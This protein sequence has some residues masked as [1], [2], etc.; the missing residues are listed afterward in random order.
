VSDPQESDDTNDSIGTICI[1]CHFWV[2]K[3]EDFKE[4]KNMVWKWQDDSQRPIWCIIPVVGS[5]FGKKM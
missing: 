4:D 5:M 3:Q 1:Q 2:S